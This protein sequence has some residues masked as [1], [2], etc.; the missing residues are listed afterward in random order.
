MYFFDFHGSINFIK[1]IRE[2]GSGWT[3]QREAERQRETEK[4]YIYIYYIR[5][6]RYQIDKAGAKKEKK[7]ESTMEERKK[8]S[9]G[10]VDG[11]ARE[12][13]LVSE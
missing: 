12:T 5:I 8:Q 11:E 9:G 7:K 10:K 1:G 6:Y 2:L 4:K 3:R 13:P